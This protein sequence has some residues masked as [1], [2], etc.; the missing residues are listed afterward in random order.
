MAFRR[1]GPQD[2]RTRLLGSS[3]TTNCITLAISIFALCGA[4]ISAYFS[5]ETNVS[6]IESANQ[7][8]RQANAAFADQR[9]WLRPTLTLVGLR[10]LDNGDA[11]ISFTVKLE[12]IGRSPARNIQ[13]QITTTVSTKDAIFNLPLKQKRQ[14]DLA[15]THANEAP[16]PGYFLFAS[17]I[18]N[19]W[20]NPDWG[21]SATITHDTYSQAWPSARNITMN[22]IGCFDYTLPSGEHGQ[23]G[24]SYVISRATA[25]G[26]SSGFPPVPGNIDL[27]G[28]L[29]QPDPFSSGYFR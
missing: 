18:S 21:S 13:S 5:H 24:F 25:N 8:S 17:E 12:N 14:C 1:K 10:F 7:A 9:P 28:V 22:I 16:R 3:K 29:F 23:T 11:N 2:R 19:I 4:A 20:P 15:Q 6:A 27:N 26:H